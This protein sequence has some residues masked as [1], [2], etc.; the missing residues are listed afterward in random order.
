MIVLSSAGG[1]VRRAW[2]VSEIAPCHRDDDDGDCG[3]QDGSFYNLSLSPFR[4]SGCPPPPPA[5]VAVVSCEPDV[6]HLLLAAV[7]PSDGVHF[8]SKGTAANA[9][10][11]DSDD[12]D[13]DDGERIVIE[14]DDDD[15]DHVDGGGEIQCKASSI[16]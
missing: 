1:Q 10:A 4:F 14:D 15:D 7:G 2:G 16:R 12:V 8:L 13:E 5:P 11:A 3:Q 6:R 9:A